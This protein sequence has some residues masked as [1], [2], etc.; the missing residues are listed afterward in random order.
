MEK[1]AHAEE[2]GREE[3]WIVFFV[4]SVSNPDLGYIMHC[5]YQL[6]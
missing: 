6:G 1:G 5:S 4:G 2:D 3:E